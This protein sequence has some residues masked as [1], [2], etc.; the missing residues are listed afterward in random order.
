MDVMSCIKIKASLAKN[1]HI[2]PS[3]VD[4]M[5]MWEYELFIRELNELVEEE[6]NQQ[7]KEMDK[8]HVNDYMKMSN[9]KN[10]QQ[11]MSR[12]PDFSK[13]N[14]GNT[15]MGGDFAKFK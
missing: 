3:E 5:Y 12:G 7:K 14:F 13:M 6:N 9:P 8:Y 11:N 4:N 2:Q 1:F 15:N 10:M